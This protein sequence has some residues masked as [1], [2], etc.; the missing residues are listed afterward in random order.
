MRRNLRGPNRGG[1]ELLDSILSPQPS[2]RLVSMCL[3][4]SQISN[5]LSP[6]EK[7]LTLFFTDKIQIYLFYCH[8]FLMELSQKEIKGG[9]LLQFINLQ[10]INVCPFQPEKPLF[11]RKHYTAAKCGKQINVELLCGNQGGGLEPQVGCPTSSYLRGISQNIGQNGLV[12]SGRVQSTLQF[13]IF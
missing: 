11:Q 9:W 10:R 12:Q 13:R 7:P 1:T 3:C 5:F 2:H 8:T 6:P 4:L